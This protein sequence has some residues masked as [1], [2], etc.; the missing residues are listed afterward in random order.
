MGKSGVTAGGCD[1]QRGAVEGRNRCTKTKRLRVEAK[2]EGKD[3]RKRTI[4]RTRK[5]ES[6]RKSNDE[7]DKQTDKS[8]KNN[9]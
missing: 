3:E 9:E 5:R 4:R 1:G 2:K 6:R 8:K 7:D